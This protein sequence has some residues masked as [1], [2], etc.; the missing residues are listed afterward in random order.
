MGGVTGVG[1]TFE[2][3]LAK[4]G[5]IATVVQTVWRTLSLIH[6]ILL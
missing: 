4:Q 3:V 6:K 5:V 1:K 2:R